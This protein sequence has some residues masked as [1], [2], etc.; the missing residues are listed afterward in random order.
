M[1]T[2]WLP[3]FPNSDRA[4]PVEEV[5]ASLSEAEF[6]ERFVLRHRPCVIRGAVSHWRAVGRWIRPPPP[7]ERCWADG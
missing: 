3:Q 1:Q 7:G 4:L 5:D 2:R 6:L